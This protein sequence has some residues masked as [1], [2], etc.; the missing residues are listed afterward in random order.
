MK[1][2]QMLLCVFATFSL[3]CACSKEEPKPRSTAPEYNNGSLSGQAWK[4]RNDG[5]PA[6]RFITM[7]KKAVEQLRRGESPD[8]AVTVLEQMGFFYQIVGDYANAIHYYQEAADSHTSVAL[9][10]RSQ[11]AIQLFGDLS[12]LYSHLGMYQEALAYSDSAI[13]ESLRQG[14]VMSADIY[15]MRA[16]VF[17][18]QSMTDSMSHCYDLGVQAVRNGRTNADKNYLEAYVNAERGYFLIETYPEIRDSVERAVGLLQKILEYDNMDMTGYQFALGQGLCLLGNVKEGLP[19]MEKASEEF[20]N[21]HD[22]ELTVYSKQVLL[23]IYAKYGMGD[24]LVKA[25]PAFSVEKDSLNNLKK[26]ELVI[27]ADVRYQTAKKDLEIQMLD[28]KLALEK[29]R[30]IVIF[31]T[32][33]LIVIATCVI[34]YFTL[35]KYKKE[36]LHRQ[37][38]QLELDRLQKSHSESKKRTQ[39]L[40]Q[41]LS[42]K[43]NS[44]HE[45]L[46][47]PQLITGELQGKFRRAFNALYPDVIP[48]LKES[49]PEI[50]PNDEL[51]CMLIYL[52]HTTEEI[53]VFLGISRQS[54]NTTRYRLRQKFHLLEKTKLDDY[55]KNFAG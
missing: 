48:A 13:N 49:H 20:I 34:I 16:N 55:I 53:A 7:Q 37:E 29:S 14:G 15:T 17:A 42:L 45:I 30:K 11:G 32:S 6:D 3:I 31:L 50:T 39:E 43:M 24:K 21:Q 35:K 5:A 25:F 52:Q 44:N 28:Q 19:M 40:E 4:L 46:T 27:G 36:K 12:T 47:T 26:A 51:V 9:P 38:K 8:D 2:Y 54:V 33:I 18:S 41:D 22:L 1:A 23:K 10:D